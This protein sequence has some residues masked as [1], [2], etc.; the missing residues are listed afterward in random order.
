MRAA[1]HRRQGRRQPGRADDRRHH[2]IGRP[3]RRL[4]HGRRAGGGLDAA[5]GERGFQRLV[6]GVVGHHGEAGVELD[7]P[8]R[9]EAPALRRATR[10]RP[11]RRRDRPPA[12]RP[13]CSRPSRSSP[14]PSHCAL[15]RSRLAPC[16]SF[17]GLT[18]RLEPPRRNSISACAGRPG[19]GGFHSRRTASPI[20]DRRRAAASSQ[21]ALPGLPRRAENRQAASCSRARRDRTSRPPG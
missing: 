15:P 8:A 4:D 13:C 10:P 12:A 20:A 14:A 7:A 9:R 2:P 17:R 11:R 19:A 21:A 6:L 5:A 16:R 18:A 3:R 1:P